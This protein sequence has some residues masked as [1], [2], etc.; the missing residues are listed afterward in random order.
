MTDLMTRALIRELG[1]RATD[2][3]AQP[4]LAARVINRG[5][6]VR[7][8]RTIITTTTVATGVAAVAVAFAIAAPA[9]PATSSPAHDNQSSSQHVTPT[10]TPARAPL[11]QLAQI[12]APTKLAS[13]NAMA[14][15]TTD[16]QIHLAGRSYRLPRGW[17]V[18]SIRTTAGGLVLHAELLTGTGKATRATGKDVLA[19]VSRTG[20]VR[21][22]AGAHV[23]FVIN[24]AGTLLVADSAPVGGATGANEAR[25]G[26]SLPSGARVFSTPLPASSVLAGF[27]N[28]T[29]VLLEDENGSPVVWPVAGHTTHPDRTPGT[30]M[31]ISTRLDRLYDTGDPDTLSLIAPD[32]TRRWQNTNFSGNVMGFA[33]SGASV[34]LL[35]PGKGIKQLT[36]LN[37]SNGAV[38]Q[39]FPLSQFHLGVQDV[40]DAVWA[41]D[42]E[43]F[44]QW[45]GFQGANAHFARCTLGTA[46]CVDLSVIRTQVLLPGEDWFD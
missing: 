45:G 16:N 4:D 19:Y 42:R 27:I 32:G 31:A 25:L 7:R 13:L 39:A 8:R 30:Q 3:T 2:M 43:V 17:S 9:H 11:I 34:A 15:A 26:F 28:N 35:T 33:P 10:P 36:I 18:A 44:V 24:P 40:V 5:R 6:I 37:S 20:S 23:P 12:Q 29:T 14:Y 41:S 46:A 1:L 21:V 38:R 22:L